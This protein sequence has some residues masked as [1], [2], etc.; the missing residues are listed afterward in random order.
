MGGIALVGALLALSQPASAAD[1][2]DGTP[3][4]LDVPDASSDIA[5]VLAWMSSD[6]KTL[7][8][9]MDVFPKAVA[10][11]KFSDAVKYVFHL[12][13]KK[14]GILDTPKPVNVVCTFDTSQKVSCW[15]VDGTSNAVLDY[16][17]GD[18][19]S[20]SGLASASGKLKVFAGRRDDPFFFNLAGFRNASAT[21]AQAVAAFKGGNTTYVKSVDATTGCPTLATGIA[22]A[23]L[24]LLSH[25]CSANALS[26]PP[27]TGAA[28]VDFF[29]KPGANAMGAGGCTNQG[30]NVDVLSLVV[31]V[32]KTLVTVAGGPF[33][34]VWASTNK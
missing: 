14:T 19:S 28:A 26:T 5:D 18:A 12:N 21:V 34:G 1:H 11:S 3:A 24:S 13:S 15:V 8:L 22:N 27:V 25:D 32:D 4:N 31:T 2:T 17:T 9:V 23:L 29:G 7:N 6:A 16:V 33:L 30:L 10:G 20:T